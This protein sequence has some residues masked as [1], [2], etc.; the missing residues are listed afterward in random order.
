MKRNDYSWLW[1]GALGALSFGIAS[2]IYNKKRMMDDYARFVK[3]R[4][5]NISEIQDGMQ[6]FNAKDTDPNKERTATRP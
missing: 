5:K 4:E 2:D 6:R 3:V 1:I